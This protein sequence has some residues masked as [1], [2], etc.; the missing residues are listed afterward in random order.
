MPNTADSLKRANAT[1]LVLRTVIR[2]PGTEG[3]ERYVVAPTPS[4]MTAEA[5]AEALAALSKPVS[6]SAVQNGDCLTI[7]CKQLS[8]SG[9]RRAPELTLDPDYNSL[10]RDLIR[11]FGHGDNPLL[12]LRGTGKSILMSANEISEWL[13]EYDFHAIGLGFSWDDPDDEARA[14]GAVGT[15]T[16]SGP[17]EYTSFRVW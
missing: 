10:I 14:A 16:F 7:T 15:L 3:I 6:C 4:P 17:I 1:L 8:T 11:S 13:Q 9:V 2:G 5:A 12:L